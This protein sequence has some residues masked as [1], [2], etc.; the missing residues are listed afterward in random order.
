MQGRR[1]ILYRPITGVGIRRVSELLSTTE[2]SAAQVS[3][4]T[5]Y[6]L[7]VIEAIAEY[8]ADRISLRKSFES[9]K[10]MVIEIVREI[11]QLRRVPT[12]R[13]DEALLQLQLSAAVAQSPELAALREE[14]AQLRQ[15][16]ASLREMYQ[17]PFHPAPAPP[18]PSRSSGAA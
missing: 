1:K 17:R 4:E 6:P 15:E 11:R 2:M 5:G 10:S 18:R 12:G 16:L 9:L 14:M 3:A 13:L 7:S 8:H